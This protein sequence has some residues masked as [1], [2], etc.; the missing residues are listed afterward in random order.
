M[1]VSILIATM[2][3]VALFNNLINKL[4]DT[5][6]QDMEVCVSIDNDKTSRIL[7]DHY[8]DKLYLDLKNNGIN[9]S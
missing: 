7:V 4:I 2:N 5:N 9:L 6:Y 3:R 1:K 8:S